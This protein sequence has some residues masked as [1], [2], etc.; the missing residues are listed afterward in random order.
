M[1]IKIQTTPRLSRHRDTVDTETQSTPRLLFVCC[2]QIYWDDIVRYFCNFQPNFVVQ[3]S[4]DKSY[5]NL[6]LYLEI[7]NIIFT[8]NIQKHSNT[9]KTNIVNI[10]S[11]QTIQSNLKTTLCKVMH[12]CISVTVYIYFHPFKKKV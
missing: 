4:Y 10:R 11:N 3:N 12:C 2:Y 1:D 8:R 5:K 9:N 7:K 6:G